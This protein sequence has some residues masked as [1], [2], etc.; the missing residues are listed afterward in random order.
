MPSTTGSTAS[1]WLGLQRKLN[2]ELPA[3]LGLATA[4]GALMIFDV[5]FVGGKVGMR[6]ALKDSEDPLGHV[7]RFGV[8]DDV[9]QHIQ[10]AAMGHAH[11]DLIDAACRRA[12][13]QLIEH[14]DD[15]LAALERKAFLSEI[16]FMQELLELLGLDQ[17]L[18]QFFLGLGVERLGVDK[19]L[20]DLRADPVFFFFALDMAIFDADLSAVRVAQ[21]V[22]DSR[23]VA[24]FSPCRPPVMNSRSR[25]QIVRPKF[26]RSS[27]AA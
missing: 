19:L 15:R 12:L 27:S 11:V 10:P 23:S 25:S 4:L 14:R 24:V 21:D 2:R 18:Q 26:S 5:A 20:A 6:R 9:R 8:A 7:A 17:L 3:G 1:R 22:E 16:F 13:D